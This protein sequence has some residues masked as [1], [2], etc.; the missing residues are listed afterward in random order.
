VIGKLKF[1]DDYFSN[2]IR[3][4]ILTNKE[5]NRSRVPLHIAALNGNKH[6]CTMIV[7]E[8]TMME[9][10]ILDEIIDLPDRDGLTP[11]YLLCE[12]GFLKEEDTGNED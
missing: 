10:N 6:F 2:K 5:P 4:F 11:L 12:K 3:H 7:K 1:V 9:V 8:A